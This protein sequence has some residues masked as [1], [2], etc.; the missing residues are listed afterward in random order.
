MGACQSLTRVGGKGGWRSVAANDEDLRSRLQQA[1]LTLFRARGYDRTTAAEIA[2]QAGVTERTFFRH[3][4]DKREVLFEGEAVLRTALTASIAAAPAGLGP[5][6]TLFSAFRSV[7][8]LLEANRPFSKP[9]QEIIAA[10][11]ALAERELAKHAALTAALAR[12]LELRG[13]DHLPAVLAA[14]AGMAAFTQATIAWFDNPAQRLGAHLD[15]AQHG[16]KALLAESA[17]PP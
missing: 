10:T 14:H 12:A 7:L 17:C 16:L 9:R 15:Q 6:D 2:A 4:P 8:P 13:V 1:A 3:F 11:P 5:L